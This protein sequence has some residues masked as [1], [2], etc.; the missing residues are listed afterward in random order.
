MVVE[1]GE[2]EQ[3]EEKEKEKDEVVCDLASMLATLT[4]GTLLS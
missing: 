2:E 1:E 4:N 3:E